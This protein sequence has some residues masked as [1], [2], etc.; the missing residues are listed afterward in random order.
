MF[1][2]IY[3]CSQVVQATARLDSPIY[4]GER[5]SFP[6]AIA[7]LSSV[8]VMVMVIL[9]PGSQLLCIVHRYRPGY[10]TSKVILDLPSMVEAVGPDCLGREYLNGVQWVKYISRMSSLSIIIR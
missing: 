7:E 10:F 6:I 9:H 2:G 5:S 1:L 4:K 8:M 3:L